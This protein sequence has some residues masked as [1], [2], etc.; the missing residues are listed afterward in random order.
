MLSSD[1]QFLNIYGVIDVQ[2]ELRVTLF[3][4][5]H[6]SNMPSSISL[7]LDVIL[8]STSLFASPKA[9]DLIAVTL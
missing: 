3:N 9:C 8:T 5:E 7:T 6:E 4:D 2:P 1:V